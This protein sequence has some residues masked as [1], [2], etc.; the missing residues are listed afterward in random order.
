MKNVLSKLVQCRWAR[1]AAL[2]AAVA[3]VLAS[4]AFSG[5]SQAHYR[6]GGAWVG[7]VSGVQW[8][9]MHAP[10]DADAKTAAA[11]LEWLSISGPFNGLAVGFGANRF[12]SAVGNFEMISN[13]TAKYILTFYAVAGGLSATPPVG[14]KVKL[15][16]IMTGTWHYTGEN[17][18]E[19]TEVLR[20]YRSDGNPDHDVVPTPEQELRTPY[21]PKDISPMSFDW[22]PQVRLTVP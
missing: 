11:K 17:S 4:V 10:L 20:M 19:S 15:I 22:H 12:S 1:G 3:A 5:Q 16:M 6:L 9:S 2:L 18:A 14:D 7:Q 21:F 8:V 13:D